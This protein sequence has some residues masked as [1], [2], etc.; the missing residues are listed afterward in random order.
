MPVAFRKGNIMHSIADPK[1]MAKALRADL[2]AH[3]L[4][5]RDWSTLNARQKDG[6]LL[7]GRGTLWVKDFRLNTVGPKTKTTERNGKV[8]TKPENLD[9]SFS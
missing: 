4:G 6:L 8:L 9:F 3:Q 5:F 7:K 2:A 1:T